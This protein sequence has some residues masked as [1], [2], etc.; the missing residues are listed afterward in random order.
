M[1]VAPQRALSRQRAMLLRGQARH[2]QH[3]QN[4]LTQMNVQLLAEMTNTRIHASVDEIAKSLQGNWRQMQ[5]HDRPLEKSR[6]RSRTRNAP[7]FDL[8]KQLFQMCGVDLT[9]IDG[10]EVTTALA[11][12]SETGSDMSRFPTFAHFASWLGL[13]PRTRITG[14]KVMSGKTQRNANRAAQALRMA[15]AALRPSQ[16]A[17]GAYYRRL[18]ARRDKPK[19]ITA[20]AHKL[21]RLIY[22]MLTKGEEYV[23]Q[24]QEYYEERYRARVLH[25]W[26]Q[27]AQRL[28]M[29]LV[30]KSGPALHAWCREKGLF[31]H[32][33][34]QRNQDFC[35]S[36]ADNAI[37]QRQANTAL[38]E[39]QVK[40][41][42][43]QRDMRRKD[44]ALAEAAALLVLQKKFQA[45]WQDA[46]I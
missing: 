14:G 11:V 16:P 34:Q 33:L 17:L 24:G 29:T 9:R 25:Q 30:A 7:K 18:C 20:A 39:L 13:C 4:A 5:T 46:D 38:R 15:A 40:H 6:K 22:T 41:E 1:I 3:M 42:Q 21:A 28:G 23:D 36:S 27:R 26:E 10:I 8:R 31:E 43:L 12:I 35:A 2:V 45:L 44:R 19:A 32:Q 37:P